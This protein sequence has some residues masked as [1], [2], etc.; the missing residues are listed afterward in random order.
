MFIHLSRKG[1]STLEYALV[2][3]IVVA[4]L[5]AM[6]IYIR[7]GISGRLKQST[8]DI[9]EQFSAA[10]STYNYT[11]NVTSH[12][13]ETVR[14]GMDPVTNITTHQTQNRTGTEYIANYTDA[15]EDYW[16]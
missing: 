3:A 16:K 8:D 15:D 9:G 1:Q 2:I 10:A 12:S 7:R 11:I 14:G 4:A 6:Q 5:L 13:R